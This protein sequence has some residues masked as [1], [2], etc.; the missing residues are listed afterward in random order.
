MIPRSIL[1]ITRNYPPKVGGLE[2][3][4]FN[5][6]EAFSSSLRTHKI[7][8]AKSKKHL[9]W[10]FPYSLVKALY[11]IRK[12]SVSHVHLCDGMLAPVGL[13][14]KGFTGKPVTVTVHGLDITYRNPLYQ[15]VIPSCVKM[16]DRIV[17]VSHSTRDE[18]LKR[19]HVV[20]ENCI[21]IP[22]GIIAD[23]MVLS[24]P[25]SELLERFETLTRLSLPNRKILFTLGH[26][27]RRKGVAWFV[28]NVVLRLPEKYVYLVAGD[29]PEKDR[30]EKIILQHHLEKRVFLLGEISNEIRNILYN[31][32]DI[33]VMPNITVPNDV[34]GFG[35]VALEAGSCGL[36][37]V[38]T[39]IQGI[40][41]A[42][43]MVF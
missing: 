8:L 23:E 19:T 4:S 21:V 13:L 41:D 30:I 20:P 18:L 27:V 43:R 38:A 1:F 25:K 16:M 11:V 17:C 33:F 7:T 12:F 2:K 9:F 40:R 31:I 34:E 6:I 29:G 39:N 32:A 5:L 10:F 28:E 22:N 15:R 24:Q 14:L 42:V 36:P 35:I 3:Y 37:V 26:L